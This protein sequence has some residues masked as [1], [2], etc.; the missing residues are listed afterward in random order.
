M[1]ALENVNFILLSAAF[2]RLDQL[3]QPIGKQPVR[4]KGMIGALDKQFAAVIADITD[5]FRVIR[6]FIP[7]FPDIGCHHIVKNL[8]DV[9]VRREKEETIQKAL[10]IPRGHVIIDVPRTELLRAEPRINKTDIGIIDDND[11]V[12]TLDDF[13]PIA[14]AIR[15]RITPDWI[16]MIVTDDKY[17]DMVSKK[18]EKLLFN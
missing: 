6:V 18:A 11:E 15:S 8:E 12:K 10:K 7:A 3:D 2:H 1:R 5:G 4:K 17:R 16:V 14:N 13:T 9:D